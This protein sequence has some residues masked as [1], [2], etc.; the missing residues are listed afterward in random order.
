MVIATEGK[1]GA[2]GRLLLDAVGVDII[3]S[4]YEHVRLD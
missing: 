3:I 2:L 4:V 1:Y